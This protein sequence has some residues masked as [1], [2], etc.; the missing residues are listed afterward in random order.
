MEKAF[1]R[2]GAMKWD[3]SQRSSTAG[4]RNS[5]RTGLLPSS[6]NGQPTTPLNRSGLGIRRLT[7]T[8]LDS[9]IV[10]VSPTSVWRVLGQAGR[11][12]PVQHSG[13][14]QSLHREPGSAGVDD[15][16]GHRDHLNCVPLLEMIRGRSQ[17]RAAVLEV[18]AHSHRFKPKKDVKKT[19]HNPLPWVYTC[20]T[21]SSVKFSAGTT[22]V[23]G[24]L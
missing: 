24:C 5:S 1:P 14:L 10:A 23:G 22:R 7:F 20:P 2:S 3:S 21:L 13:G 19:D 9:N 17:K 8:M 18:P 11:L 15:R 4:R 16:S 12:L 6:R